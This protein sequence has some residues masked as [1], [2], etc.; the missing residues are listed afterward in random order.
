ME[1]DILIVGGGL[2]G[3]VA[4]HT[5]QKKYPNHKILIVE[6]RANPGGRI[7][8]DILQN[9]W[10][11]RGAARIHT[12]HRRMM[13][14]L[15]DHKL[16]SSLHS[17]PETPIQPLPHQL[18][19]HYRKE[20]AKNPN[21]TPYDIVKEKDFIESTGYSHTFHIVSASS[22]LTEW[23]YYKPDSFSKWFELE[24]GWSRLIQKFTTKNTNILFQTK[25][26]TIRR[27]N[28]HWTLQTTN[29]Q[30]YTAPTIVLAV[31]PH[32]VQSMMRGSITPPLPKYNNEPL[33]RVFVKTTQPQVKHYLIENPVTYRREE[34]GGQLLSLGQ[35]TQKEG[36]FELYYTAGKTANQIMNDYVSRPEATIEKWETSFQD[37]TNIPL[38]IK[39]VKIA[40]WRHGV[41]W[42]APQEKTLQESLQ[43]L[44]SWSRHHQCYL[45][46][47]SYSP[48]AGWM[49]GALQSI[50][51]FL[52]QFRLS[53]SP[54]HQDGGAKSKK[55][56]YTMK[57]VAKHN[58]PNDAW[59]VIKNKVYD[60]T[61]WTPMHPG[62]DVIL[63]GVGKDATA[64]FESAHPNLTL[65]RKILRRYSI[66]TLQKPSSK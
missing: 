20:F 59:I 54:S 44:L 24:G 60:I 3:L 55:K 26:K 2:S 43:S 34:D 61:E 63:S 64:M 58:Q 27:N 35:R 48:S 62:G 30:T 28:D 1:N 6:K 38:Q 8:T 52:S 45:I 19:S 15:N 49:E 17:L 56:T 5:L 10:L 12:T 32:V 41:E 16:T 22:F 11:D 42:Y 53:S 9:A 7:Q 37:M 65:P 25:I 29:N 18:W 66:G 23:S 51:F 31:Q 36:W 40:H 47:D 57:E 50:S 39:N 21:Q 46:G 4:Y 14:L 33:L 13:K